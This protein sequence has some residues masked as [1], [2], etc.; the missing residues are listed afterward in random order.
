MTKPY[1]PSN[2]TAGS[3]FMR[4]FCDRCTKDDPDTGCEI[5]MLSMMYEIEEPDFPKEWVQDSEGGN[6]RCTAFTPESPDP[7]HH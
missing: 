4:K 1:R 5:V 3:M 6:P 7:S 2:G